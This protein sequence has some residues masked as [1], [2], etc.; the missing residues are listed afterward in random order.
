MTNTILPDDFLSQQASHVTAEMVDF[1]KTEIPEMAQLYACVID[2]ALSR[3]ECQ[4]LI[5]AAEAT[6]G[7]TWE[8][9]M[10]KTGASKQAMYEDTRKCG[11][12]IWD[13]KDVAG[14]I[15][16]RIAHLPEVQDIL[17]LESRP[18]ITGIG[19]MKKGEVWTLSRPNERMRF[20][21]YVGGE[22]FRPHCDAIY[23]HP[24]TKERSYFTLHLYLNDSGMP[25]EEE[26]AKM[27]AEERS[28]AA[29][30]ATIGGATRFHA[31]NMKRKYDVEPRAGRILL[32][33]QRD[34]MHSGDDVVQ[35]VKYTMRT[36][37]MYACEDTEPK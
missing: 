20:L 2:N 25:P 6:S 22:Y 12:I 4:L 33:Q 37:L 30:S 28:E 24:E 23:R 21:K 7:G 17:R 14:R 13:S 8:R 29:A 32:F 10:V 5:K 36:D 3:E 31:M 19:P 16:K 1:A 35:G 15:W 27:T 34:T 26:L 18:R 11:R 9:A